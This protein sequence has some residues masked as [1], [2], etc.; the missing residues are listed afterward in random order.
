MAGRYAALSEKSNSTQKKTSSTKY[1]EDLSETSDIAAV[2]PMAPGELPKPVVTA[3]PTSTPIAQKPVD[4]PKQ[5]P[6][7]APATKPTKKPKKSVTRHDSDTGMLGELRCIDLA[8]RGQCANYLLRLILNNRDGE[9]VAEA[10][11][12]RTN[13]TLSITPPRAETRDPRVRMLKEILFNSSLRN[14][15][16]PHITTFDM[17][18]WAVMNGR[19]EFQLHLQT[20]QSEHLYFAGPLLTAFGGESI[21]ILLKR[22]PNTNEASSGRWMSTSAGFMTSMIDS[23]RLVSNNGRGSI[24]IELIVADHQTQEPV[25]FG[26]TFTRMLPPILDLTQDSIYFNP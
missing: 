22:N 4:T 15:Q 3:T 17:Q 6:V 20:D 14:P 1:S 16:G 21:N 24:R 18:S 5:T 26:M 10:V 11:I 12:R 13:A 9:A 7:E 25:S 2:A 8:K 19:S 23:A